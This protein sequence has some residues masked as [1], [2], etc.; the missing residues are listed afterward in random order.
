MPAAPGPAW[1][2]G[3][4]RSLPEINLPAVGIQAIKPP[5]RTLQNWIML[6]SSNRLKGS[7]LQ[8]MRIIS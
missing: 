2:S 3:S 1:F 4:R 5:A 6:I 8:R 7:L